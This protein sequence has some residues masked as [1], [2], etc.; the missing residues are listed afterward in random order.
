MENKLTAVNSANTNFKMYKSGK[1][2][3]FAC[4]MIVSSLAAMGVA[5]SVHADT[6]T[7]NN[8]GAQPQVTQTQAN[9]NSSTNTSTSSTAGNNATGNSIAASLKSAGGNGSNQTIKT[10]PNKSEIDQAVSNAKQQPNLNIS[11]DPDQEIT[12]NSKEEIDQKIKNDYAQQEQLIEAK[13]EQAKKAA[14]AKQNYDRYNNMHGNTGIL[15][16]SVKDAKNVPGLTVKK[17]ADQTTTINASDSDAIR[18]WS[19]NTQS[20]YEAQTKAIQNAIATQ[21]QN[22]QEYDAAYKDWQSKNAANEAKYQSQM[23]DY[24]RKLEEYNQTI[25]GKPTITS[26][27]NT[28]LVG[29]TGTPGSIGYYSGMAVVTTDDGYTSLGQVSWNSNTSLIGT[30]K[31]A[32]LTSKQGQVADG[33]LSDFYDITD[34]VRNN[35]SIILTN[36]AH[37]GY[38]INYDLKL[39]FANTD[40]S[41]TGK[42]ILGPANDGSIEFDFYGG[43]QS[44]NAGLNI[45]SM[46]FVYHGTNVAAPVLM[47]SLFSD[48]DVRQSFNTNLGNV[49]AWT[50]NNSHV[51]ILGDNYVDNSSKDEDDQGFNSSPKGTGV[52]VGKGSNFYYHFY[53]G[54]HNGRPGGDITNPNVFD[55]GTQFN[56]FGKGASLAQ[57]P[58]PPIPQST[59]APSR[60]TSSVH[61][62]YD[63][64]KITPPTNSGYVNVSYHYDYTNY[65]PSTE[66]HFTDGTKIADNQVFSDGSVVTANIKATLPV[67][68]DIDGGLK[69]YTI[70]EDYSN[71]A[72]Y[73]NKG[74]FKVMNGTQDVTSQWSVKDNGNGKAVLTL[75]DPSK[76]NGETVTVEPMWTINTDVPNGTEFVNN[77]TATVNDVPGTPS[78]SKITTF[79]QQPTKDVEIGDNVQG[80][81]PNSI[82]GQVVAAGSTVTYPLSDKNGLPANREQQVTSHVITDNL[83]SALNYV[84]YKAYL[85]DKDGKLQDV[86]SHVLLTQDGQKLT[87]TDDSY[88][89]GLYNQDPS[90]AFA[91][92]IIDLVVKANNDTKVIPNSFDS[93]FTY[94]DENGTSTEKKTSN[95]VNISTYT[96]TATKD[97]ELG[98]DVQ[99]D[100][101]NTIA[102]SLVEAGTLVTWPM[103]TKSLPAN[104]AQDVVS[105]T[106]T[107]NLD[108]NLSFVSFKAYLPDKDGKLQDVTSHVQMKQDG[109]KLTFTDDATLIKQYNAD[110]K[111]EQSLPV[112]DLVTK[113]NGQS[114][115]IPNDFD[116]QLVFKDGK[117]N[118]TLKTTSN[119]V[120]I[121]TATAPNPVKEDLN[122]Q[123]K[124]IDGQ[125]VNENQHLTMQLDWDLSNDKGVN[126][127]PEM[128]KKGFY[129]ADP[130]DAKALEAGDLSKAR[131]L[132]QNGNK[133]SG[134][135]FH[136]YNSLSEAP[137]FIQEQIKDNDL[138]ARFNG[139]FVVAQAD[140]PQAFY[141]KYVKTGS[142]L[143]VQIPVTVKKGF[144]GSFSN[145]A[146]QFGFGK[147]T[148]TNTVTN[149]V[150]PT[151]KQETPKPTTPTATPVAT[152]TAPAAAPEQLSAPVSQQ[153]PEAQQSQLPQTGNTNDAAIFGLA[154]AALIGSASLAGLDLRKHN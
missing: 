54:T 11:K 24:H 12:G 46:Q 63:T 20:D 89:L 19:T 80:D 86:T 109:Q 74:T 108:N 47:N 91:L 76:A 132:D 88:L 134:I 61:Y 44:A 37:D 73:V 83:D 153:Q 137:E 67:A 121:K 2:W 65:T 21:K 13:K 70:T 94:K 23:A 95:T 48:L 120:S 56:L 7:T 100:T 122:D 98:D 125:E 85:P 117:G 79:T 49:I 101:S 27:G 69:S 124:N 96:P 77:A 87:F 15:D 6:T 5:T 75:I 30:S 81:T 62:H 116:S 145:T 35:G 50:P 32:S 18:N 148:P 133:V 131:V 45:S 39:T 144:K 123:G 22:N 128:I 111:A 126:A 4:S 110:K 52:M 29:T 127:T 139:P 60:K 119:K 53:N 149:F 90:V 34:V 99:G 1:R 28:K 97:V 102:G 115:L 41:S 17:D 135:S 42:V 68:A 51:S 9:T 26:N 103:S 129:F 58:T 40:T 136:K 82:N 151:P 118:T 64:A 150:K 10:Y 112:I 36:V 33:N 147:A 84:S 138:E 14:E 152:P 106:E 92:P 142:K 3:L 38:G 31:R 8:S 59:P 114:K 16:N 43:Y 71:F 105:H 104:R 140:D 143:K 107:E 66:K 78:S 57:S 25:N 141:D 93:E 72:K 146:Y 113:V 55:N 130:L 154:A